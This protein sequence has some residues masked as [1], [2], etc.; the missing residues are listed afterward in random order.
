MINQERPRKTHVPCHTGAWSLERDAPRGMKSPEEQ[1]HCLGKGL[2][3]V[4]PVDLVVISH[5]N[6]PKHLGGKI[7]REIKILSNKQAKNPHNCPSP[8]KNY[9]KSRFHM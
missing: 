6:L 7:F 3:I 9:P 2:E 8:A 5:S 4:V 1:Q